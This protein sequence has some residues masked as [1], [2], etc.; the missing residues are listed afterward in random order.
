VLAR[1]GTGDKGVI[2]LRRALVQSDVYPR[3]VI[4]DLG[5][6]SVTAKVKAKEGE[7]DCCS[8]SFF[9]GVVK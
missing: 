7:R 2:A 5:G 1:S 8:G 3:L 9:F 4:L 6:N